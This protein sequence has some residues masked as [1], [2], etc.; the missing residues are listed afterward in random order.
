MKFCK[1]CQTSKPFSEFRSDSSRTGGLSRMC[2]QCCRAHDKIKYAKNAPTR[3]ATQK[4]FRQ[5]NLE[6]LNAEGRR[7]YWAK[8]EENVLNQRARYKREREKRIRDQVQYTQRR[9][10]RKLQAGVFEILPKELRRLKQS[11]C[12]MCGSPFEH[13]D[14]VVPLSR[15]GRHSIGN[16]APSCASCNLK[17]GFK[18]LVEMKNLTM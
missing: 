3:I 16:I 10:A 12:Y 7:R 17:K 2:K 1:R 14:H 8:R 18:Y 6:R 13:I 11:P 15:G 5:R 9:R 4:R